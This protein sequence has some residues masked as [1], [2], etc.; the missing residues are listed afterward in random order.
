MRPGSN[1][2]SSK[3]SWRRTTSVAVALILLGGLAIAVYLKWDALDAWAPNVGVGAFS[4][5]LTILVIQRIVEQEAEL[6]TQPRRERAFTV[7]STAVF[8]FARMAAWDFAI[9]HTSFDESQFPTDPIEALDR[10][11]RRMMETDSPRPRM[12]D[13]R[14]FLLAEGIALV[15]KAQAVSDADRELLPADVAVAIDN[16]S[17]TFGGFGEPFVDLVQRFQGH[18]ETMDDFFL[19]LLVPSVRQLGVALRESK[20]ARWPD[21]GILIPRT[22]GAE[23]AEPKDTPSRT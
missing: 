5:A 18:E 4:I 11:G 14:S 10:W 1:S 13:G 20:G 2:G 19:A 21:S 12:N 9:T 23:G 15:R 17:Q 16:L 8:G 22:P 6:R 3:T 7:L